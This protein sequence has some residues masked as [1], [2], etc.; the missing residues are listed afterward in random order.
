MTDHVQAQLAVTLEV[1]GA[2]LSVDIELRRI[3]GSRVFA[4]KANDAAGVLVT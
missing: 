2:S 4:R 1:S 3:I